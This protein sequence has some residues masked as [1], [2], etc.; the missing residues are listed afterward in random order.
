MS[1]VLQ[2]ATCVPGLA[3]PGAPVAAGAAMLAMQWQL[4]RSERLAPAE[5]EALQMRQLR[6]LLA[7]A[8]SSVPFYAGHLRA[9]GLASVDALDAASFRRWPILQTREVQAHGGVL[10]A[11]SVPADHGAVVER[12]TSGSSGTPK[13][14]L[15]TQAATFYKDALVVRD[16]LWHARDFAGKF[17]GIHFFAQTAAHSGWNPTIEAAFRTGPGISGSVGTDV[18][19]Q[20]DWLVAERPAYLL[21]SPSNLAAL[22]K[23]SVQR[24]VRPQGLREALTYTE[25][26]PRGLRQALREHWGV[27]LADLYSCT[28]AG[29]LALQ[30]PS[31]TRYHVQAENVYLEVLREDGSACVPGETGRVVITP[32]HNFA[33]PLI[34]YELGDY[35][36]AGAPCSCGRGLPV[37]VSI[38]GRARNMARDPAGRLFQPGFDAALEASRLDVE[39]FQFVQ[40][41]PQLVEMSYVKSRELTAEE[42]R[43]FSEAVAATLPYPFEIRYRRVAAIARGAG[44]KFEGFVS[45]IVEG[46]EAA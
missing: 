23:R 25:P 9:A 11:R 22:V 27:P 28:E 30:C 32:L 3:W 5:I 40:E 35:A 7:H 15:D 29:A 41:T 4:E 16:H 44:G 17:A 10:Q 14:I 26:L 39:Q 24:D 21:T 38:A 1:A 37:L 45:R 46:G 34:R 12:F 6:V 20:L 2:V 13:R 36:V 18:E 31:G 8:V 19:A 42:K 43:G 33:M